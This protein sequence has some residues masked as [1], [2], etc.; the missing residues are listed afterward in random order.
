MIELSDHDFDRLAM[1][2]PEIIGFVS[3]STVDYD[4]AG[5]DRCSRK[6]V[7]PESLSKLERQRDECPAI[8]EQAAFED[9]PYLARLAGFRRRKEFGPDEIGALF[10]ARDIAWSDGLGNGLYESLLICRKYGLGHVL[11]APIL[12]FPLPFLEGEWEDFTQAY[13][14]YLGR[15]V[16]DLKTMEQIY[17]GKFTGA[18]QKF[19]VLWQKDYP[20]SFFLRAYQRSPKEVC[21]ELV[22]AIG[23]ERLPITPQTPA[24]R[25]ALMRFWNWVREK[26]ARLAAV[27]ADVLREVLGSGIQ[28]IAN[29]HELPVLDFDG[30]ARAFDIPSVAV[31]PLLLDDGL[32][33][34]QYMAYYAQLYHDLTEKRPMVSVRMN[35]SAATPMFVPGGSLIR[36]WYDQAV[37]HGAGSFYF[38]TRDYPCND[39]PSTYDGP[40]PGNPVAATLPMERWETSLDI[41]GQLST[42]KRFRQPEAEVYILIPTDSALLNRAEWRRIYTAFSVL[43]ER[44]VF[45]RFIADRKIEREGIPAHVRLLIA[46]E[47]EFLST[48][49]Q[50]KLE[51]YLQAGGR[52]V[53]TQDAF[54]DRA[55]EPIKALAKAQVVD[56]RLFDAFP[57]GRPGDEKVYRQAEETLAEVVA[58]TG[59]D[60]KDWVFE[61]CCDNLPP[62]DLRW[63]RPQDPDVYFAPWLYE[64][65]SEWIMPYLQDL[66]PNR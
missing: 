34:R 55:G 30:Q 63:L 5:Y 64:H 50:E 4:V 46:P 65:G 37:R 45:T 11:E 3:G 21:R 47:L 58:S 23:M 40:I 10:R 60:T 61:V 54:F 62:T 6:E 48:Q 42:H 41:L 39:D 1:D 52:L 29:P 36:H 13:R 49:L 20:L 57:L 22:N 56:R 31:R 51:T 25:A 53:V 15:F 43:A 26:Q 19:I 33:L 59:C 17:G 7:A 18:G 27:Q 44:R 9:Q 24:E 66:P 35:L 32:M 12:G 14:D 8:P 16:E 38:W 28:V 2:S